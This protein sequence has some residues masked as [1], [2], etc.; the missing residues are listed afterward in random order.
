MWANRKRQQQDRPATGYA[1]LVREKVV[2]QTIDKR[3]IEGIVTGDYSDAERSPTIV[4][5]HVQDLRAVVSDGRPATQAHPIPG[6]VT[7]P[8]EKI[9]A[10][11][12]GG[13]T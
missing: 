12:A 10:I 6:D 9:A 5:S 11:Q 8:L 3:S 7:I 4:L 2:V 1:H 13:R